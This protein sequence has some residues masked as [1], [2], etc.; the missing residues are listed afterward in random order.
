[1]SG[2]CL[3]QKKSWKVIQI[4]YFWKPLFKES[5]RV[6][7]VFNARMK[8]CD[9]YGNLV[10]TNDWVFINTEHYTGNKHFEHPIDFVY[11]FFSSFFFLQKNITFWNLNKILLLF[12]VIFDIYKTE[13]KTTTKSIRSWTKCE[14]RKS[15][16]FER[17]AIYT[18]QGVNSFECK[19]LN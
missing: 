16:L 17:L 8:I 7:E 2:K 3:V 9:S 4:W 15:S 12:I 19:I 13:R 18:S 1:M 5:F 11:F 14:M 10:G 6:F